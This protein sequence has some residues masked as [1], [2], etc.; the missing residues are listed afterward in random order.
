MDSDRPMKVK[1]TNSFEDSHEGKQLSDKKEEPNE[2]PI[3]LDEE[4]MRVIEERIA[5]NRPHIERS[6]QEIPVN[7]RGVY[8]SV[9]VSFIFIALASMIN[10]VQ[11][12]SDIGAMIQTS[13]EASPIK[14]YSSITSLTDLDQYI[15]EVA[16]PTSY[17]NLGDYNYFVGLKMSLKISK[18]VKEKVPDYSQA[19]EYQKENPAIGPGSTSSGEYTDRL[20]IWKYTQ[21]KG[22]VLYVFPNQTLGEALFIWRQAKV[23]WTQPASFSSLTIEYLFQN[24]NFA[25]TLYYIQEILSFSDGSLQLS[26]DQTGAFIEKFEKIT[27]DS[28]S[29]SVLFVVYSLGFSMQIF[30]LIQNLMRTCTTLLVKKKL[31]LVWHEYIEIM[32][33]VLALI[34]LVMF[35][36]YILG[37]IGKYHLPVSSASV[38]DGIIGYC[39]NFRSFVRITALAALLIS[40]KV[41]VVL[42]YKFPSFGIL[43]DTI[44]GAKTDIINFMVITIFLM[45]GFAFMG[46]LAFGI[47]VLEFSTTVN[48][49]AKLFSMTL[50]QEDIKDSLNVQNSTLSS[51]FM[52]FYL[53]I[54]FMVLL[55]TFLAIVMSTYEILRKQ[56]QLMLEAKAE[57]IANQSAEWFSALVNLI[58]FRAA[59]VEANA[60]EY[61]NIQAKNQENLTEKEKEDMQEQLKMHETL[62][63]ASTRVDL[64][65]IFK[66]NFGKLSS[67]NRPTLLTRVQNMD[68]ISSVLRKI[69]ERNK[70]KELQKE[71][72]KLDV[73]HNFNLIIQMLIYLVYIVIFI[74]MILLRLRIGESFEVNKLITQNFSV[75]TFGTAG[76]TFG[77]ILVQDDVFQYLNSTFLPKISGKFLFGQNYFI[78][79]QRAR[80]T[81]NQYVLQE[82]MN[83]FSNEAIPSVISSSNLIFTSTDFRGESTELLY[84]YTQPGTLGSFEKSGGYVLF[85]DTSEDIYAKIGTLQLDNVLGIKGSSMAIEWITYNANYNLFTYSYILVTHSLSGNMI[86]EIY[87]Q[88]IDLDFFRDGVPNRGILEIMYFFFTLYYIIIEYKE[89]WIIWI[90]VRAEEKLKQKGAESLAR[91]IEKFN[92]HQE[93]EGKGC[94]NIVALM[95]NFVKKGVIWLFKLLV[96]FIESLKRYFKQDS[97]N[98]LDIISIFMSI[99]ILYLIFQLYINNFIKTFTVDESSN[100]DFFGEFSAINDVLTTY[101][102]LAC[103]NSLIVFMRLLQFYKFSKHLSL[104]TDILDSAKLDLIFFLAMFAIVLFAYTLMGYLLLGHIL[105]QFSNMPHALI[106]SYLMLC[107]QFHTSEIFGADY[108]FGII[109]LVTL[110][111]IFTLIMLNMFIAIINSHFEEISKN[112][113]KDGNEPGF[114]ATIFNVIRARIEGQLFLKTVNQL[115][116]DK[117][118]HLTKFNQFAPEKFDEVYHIEKVQTDATQA[119]NWMKLIESMLY[120]KSDKKIELFKMKATRVVKSTIMDAPAMLAEVCFMNEE[121]WRKESLKERIRIWRSMALLSRENALREVERAYIEGNEIPL[122]N[123]IDANMKNLWEI[124]SPEE[125]I[126]LW[127]GD[128]HFDH[129]ERVAVWNCLTFIPA[130]FGFNEGENVLEEWVKLKNSAKI[131]K[132]EK[133]IAN[134]HK[135][136]KKIKKIK[137]IKEE[138]KKPDNLENQKS[139]DINESKEENEKKN[140]EG[141]REKTKIRKTGERVKIIRKI[142]E[143]VIDFK[144]LLWLSLSYDEHALIS[145]FIYQSDI[146]EAEIIGYLNLALGSDSIFTLDGMDIIADNLLDS[147]IYSYVEANCVCVAEANQ[148]TSITNEKIACELEINS[149][150]SYKQYIIKEAENFKASYQV[151]LDE[152]K[153]IAK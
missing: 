54:F 130:T 40:F 124:N 59:N 96:A 88:P 20:G 16:L 153:S 126:E 42:R 49:F 107:G 48:A 45:V 142:A 149:L 53:V 73:K 39:E 87:T 150:K 29:I 33:V 24:S 57:L 4:D 64:I 84:L 55:N 123:K 82:N 143:K 8:L 97:F 63:I 90:I 103:F 80:I 43:F 152:F 100:Y 78:N 6:L 95:Y 120:S 151:A 37:D 112:E 13:Y 81:L 139:M 128:R 76:I 140:E 98:F 116:D 99:Y 22:Y 104:L 58:L 127:I 121:I 83:S 26:S 9:A 46:N 114:F 115:I 25:C 131:D 1:R 2:E 108:I 21:D 12:V 102:I 50:G 144:L 101:R 79:I 129:I 94:G 38:F 125:K 66:T 52:V 111:M 32:S 61:E 138:I 15:K 23:M 146:V 14:A 60:L 92:G 44:L 17:T 119:S 117:N 106:S 7:V 35:G 11:S 69:L 72:L 27:G 93:I 62:I 30:K 110:I 135:W 86:E 147:I 18:L 134:N 28:L 67:L 105:P 5:Q 132:A 19:V 136:I 85:L 56:G 89:W 118:H 31:D 113:K 133:I 77:E 10:D 122:M 71:R 34:S 51:I 141:K 74:L 148:I 68:K 137:K 47:G 145:L 36:V 70:L 41:I 3:Q 65:K 109:F 91:V 75:P